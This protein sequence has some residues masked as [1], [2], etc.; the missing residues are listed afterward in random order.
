MG[1]FKKN[2]P[3][4][5][6]CP[7]CNCITIA[8]TDCA[9]APYDPFYWDLS[10]A[11]LT[12]DDCTSCATW[13]GDFKLC[14]TGNDTWESAKSSSTSCGHTAG[15]PLW[16]LTR[17]GGYY[18]LDA[19]GL[20]YRWRLATGSWSCGRQNTL[21]L[22]EPTPV[23]APCG[24]VPSTLDLDPCILECGNCTAGTTPNR[25][26]LQFA[27]ITDKCAVFWLCTQL[28]ATFV[29][30]VTT[31]ICFYRYPTAVLV[32]PCTGG[33]TMAFD[34][35]CQI[36]SQ[37]WLVTVRGVAGSPQSYTEWAFFRWSSGGGAFDCSASRT[38]T[39]IDRHDPIFCDFANATCTITP[40]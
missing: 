29:L 15:D 14:Y 3:G 20:G 13:N 4:C 35:W 33:N 18:N 32:G 10:V 31:N 16:K 22:Q 30:D 23:P 1:R 7:P 12:N 38:A 27:N 6:C 8:T 21:T 39:L 9:T 25:V 36:D 11:G 2:N 5:K 37:G 28:N 34:I 17:S 24:N 19:L 26:Q 40:L